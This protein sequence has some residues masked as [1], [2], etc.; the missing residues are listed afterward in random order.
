M[1]YHSREKR[2][3]VRTQEPDAHHDMPSSRQNMEVAIT[4]SQQHSC[5]YKDPTLTIPINIASWT[6]EF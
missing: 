3:I 2:K 6:E 5:Q 1:K 4:K